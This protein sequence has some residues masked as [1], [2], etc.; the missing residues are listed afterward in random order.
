MALRRNGLAETTGIIVG[1]L[2]GLTDIES[3]EFFPIENENTSNSGGVRVAKAGQPYS[4]IAVIC[5]EIF[6][7]W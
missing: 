7:P 3:F 2:S 5:V 6:F 4:V 1:W